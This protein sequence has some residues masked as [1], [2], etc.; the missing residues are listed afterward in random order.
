MPKIEFTR[1]EK[2]RIVDQVQRYFEKELDQDLG[3]FDA[4]FLLDFFSE[5]MGPFYYNKGLADARSVLQNK[6]EDIDEAIYEIEQPIEF[7]R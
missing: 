2:E 1:D 6:L 5:K 3:Q 4:E 7:T